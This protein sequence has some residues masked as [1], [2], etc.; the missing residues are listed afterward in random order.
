LNLIASDAKAE[1]RAVKDK[2]ALEFAATI[3]GVLLKV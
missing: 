1:G 2:I 3:L